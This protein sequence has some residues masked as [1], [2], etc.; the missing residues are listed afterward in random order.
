MSLE[1]VFSLGASYLFIY[2]TLKA[3]GITEGSW[4]S[5]RGSNTTKIKQS[6][7]ATT[8]HVHLTFVTLLIMQCGSV[9]YLE[10]QQLVRE[11]GSIRSMYEE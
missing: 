5:C 2:F 10:C 4:G 3:K 11:G 8:K 9:R 7:A 1:S 6:A